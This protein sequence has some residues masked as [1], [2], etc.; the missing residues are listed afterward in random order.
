MSK[1]YNYLR[2]KNFRNNFIIA[3]VSIVVF[4]A[5]IFYS[6]NLYTRHGEGLPVPKLKGLSVEEAIQLLESKG[7]RYQIDSVYLNDKKPGEVVEQ[8]PDAN[9]NVKQNRTI[10]LTIITR[11]APNI[12]FPDIDGKT[13]LEARA[14]LNNYGLKLGDT[15]YTSDVARDV[16]LQISFGGQSISTN[17]QVPKGSRISLVLGD[18]MGASEVDLPNLLGLNLNEA[19]LSLLGSS[20]NLG[21]IT[22]EG[23]LTDTLNA[24]IT[25]QFPALSDSLSKVSIG[26]QV[27]V[28]LSNDN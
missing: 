26:T 4:L 3:I 28:V 10:Y 9:T 27:D 22:Y 18:G 7:L 20:L 15:T 12:N 11:Q 21:S 5:I 19:R 23:I 2:T 13:F 17:Q 6:L 16:V 24:R 8:D 1:F 25:K 14:I